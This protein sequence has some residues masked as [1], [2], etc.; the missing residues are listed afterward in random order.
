MF[1]EFWV[2][3]KTLQVGLGKFLRKL[4]ITISKSSQNLWFASKLQNLS[5][6]SLIKVW[7]L[8]FRNYKCVNEIIVYL[9]RIMLLIV[10]IPLMD[11]FIYITL[12][13]YI[14][15]ML[16]NML[17]S[18]D[19]F[20]V[21]AL[22]R[23]NALLLMQVVVVVVVIVVVVVYVVEVVRCCWICCWVHAYSYKVG[24]SCPIECLIIHTTLIWEPML[25]TLI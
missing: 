22:S 12:C 25:Y 23:V 13:G 2:M 6:R 7:I 3:I 21:V 1:C 8:E 5:I 19:Y 24:G 17:L 16:L 20:E 11:W 18:D 15:I 10:K 14:Y 4:S 9:Q